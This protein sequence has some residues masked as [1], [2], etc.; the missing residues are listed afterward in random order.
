MQKV[1]YTLF[2]VLF[3]LSCNSQKEH[4]EEA[5]HII[6]TNSIQIDSI[7]W[8]E[9][10]KEAYE[11]FDT[12]KSIKEINTI[13]KEDIIPKLGDNHSFL[14]DASAVIQ[15]QSETKIPFIES[16]IINDS[17]GYINVPGFIG[18]GK[19]SMGFSESLQEKIKIIDEQGVAHWIIDLRNN[20]GGNMWPMLM[21]LAPLLQEGVL[22]YAVNNKNKFEP[23]GYKDG[24]LMSSEHEVIKIKNHY[25]L[26][27]PWK[28]IIVLIGR[29]TASSG[30]AV[31]IS[32]KGTQDV[33]H[34][35]SPTLG[36]STGNKTYKL[37][38][39]SW[40][41]LTTHILAD[42]NKVTYGHKVYPDIYA[43]YAKKKAVDLVVSQ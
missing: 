11:K 26:K 42:R 22:G 34:V 39:G 27:T 17:I 2:I 23:W 30:E 24:A 10:K 4:F 32:F 13:I 5:L 29:K 16:E 38:D 12:A 19:Q 21:G 41:N 9:I 28:K 43:V 14:L 1:F 33:I 3:F 35:G 6:E 25:D 15:I 7:D 20:N 36:L 31:A 18:Y 37:S 8:A 40:L